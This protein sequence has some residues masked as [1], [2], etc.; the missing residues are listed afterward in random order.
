MNTQIEQLERER[1]LELAQEY[2]Q[3]GYEV[4]LPPNPEELPDFLKDY[5]PEMIV[6]RGE[7]AVG[8]TRKSESKSK[9]RKYV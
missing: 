2:R 6:R 7:E 1:L 4:L 5:R 8:A 9:K 3:K